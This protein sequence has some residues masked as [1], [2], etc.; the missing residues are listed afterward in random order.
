MRYGFILSTKLYRE[1][2]EGEDP[3]A[4]LALS[5]T[6]ASVRNL[7]SSH[8]STTS[9]IF[10]LLHIYYRKCLDGTDTKFKSCHRISGH[11]RVRDPLASRIQICLQSVR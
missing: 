2:A 5:S 3:E 10:L 11:G 1:I 6:P 7:E 8:V 9:W 4:Y